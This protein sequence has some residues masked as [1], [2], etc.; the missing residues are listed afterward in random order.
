MDTYLLRSHHPD[1]YFALCS[2]SRRNLYW[3]P[4]LAAV[5]SSPSL[6][7]SGFWEIGC[8]LFVS[9]HEHLPSTHVPRSP[10]PFRPWGGIGTWVIDLPVQVYASAVNAYALV[11]IDDRAQKRIPQ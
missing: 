1:F 9:C 10:L 3:R 6:V 8:M 2:L 7:T 11:Y 5:P 4:P